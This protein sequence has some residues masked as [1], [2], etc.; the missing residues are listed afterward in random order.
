VASGYAAATCTFEPRS[1]WDIAGGVALVHAASGQVQLS[2][3]DTVL[4]NQASSLL[5]SFFAFGKNCPSFL[6]KKLGVD[7]A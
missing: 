1:E 7:T 3:G 5:P 6:R 4:F 2:N